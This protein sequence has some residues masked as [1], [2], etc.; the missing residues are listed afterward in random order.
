MKR[1]NAKIFGIVQGVG[2]RWIV[3]R[4]A[5]K[6]FIAGYVRN[7]P[8]GNVEVEAQ[9]SLESLER[10]IMALQKGPPIGNV[11]KL[12]LEWLPPDES[13]IEFKIRF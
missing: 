7:L 3:V 2:F 6:E 12:E 10:F 13:L 11:T 5:A 8:D 9:A 1:F 4:E